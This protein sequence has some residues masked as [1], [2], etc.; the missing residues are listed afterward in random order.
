M[1]DTRVSKQHKKICGHD[2]QIHK[3]KNSKINFNNEMSQSFPISNGMKQS[4]VLAQ[5]FFNIVSMML[6]ISTEDTDSNDKIYVRLL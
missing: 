1:A 5:S 6:Q 3:Y 2:H 4:S